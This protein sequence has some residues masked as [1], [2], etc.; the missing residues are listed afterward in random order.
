MFH[1]YLFVSSSL[2][3]VLNP[4]INTSK[5]GQT[6]EVFP[7]KTGSLQNLADFVVFLVHFGIKSKIEKP[8]ANI[9][10]EICTK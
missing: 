1:L 8:V 6:I 4:L 2:L 7:G 9:N 10:Y 3:S 5:S